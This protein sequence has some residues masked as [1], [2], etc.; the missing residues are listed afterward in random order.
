MTIT[1]DSGKI[2]L[3]VGDKAEPKTYA[4]LTRTDFVRYQGAS[5]DFHPLHHDEL[6]AKA[7]G[8]P[9]VFSV[10]MLQAGLLATYLTD[11]MGVEQLRRFKVRFADQVWPGDELTCSATVTDVVNADG[12]TRV[13]VELRC[14]RQTGSTAL[15]G[16]AEFVLV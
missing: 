16:D 14:M 1:T 2:E 4:P 3:K 6:F 13:T 11:W 15:E 7:T 8:F 9:S 5:G 10:G 12:G